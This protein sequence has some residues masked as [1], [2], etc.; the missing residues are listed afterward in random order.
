MRQCGGCTLCCKL[1]PVEEL[2]KPAGIR[3]PHVRTGKGCSIY[4][5][6][7][8]SCR[9]W[10][11]LWL[12]GTE[13]EDRHPLPIGRP[14]RT[15]YV[16]DEVPDLVRARDNTTGEVVAEMTVMQVWVDP[17]FPDAWQDPALLDMLER[18]NVAAL[19]RYDSSRA[20]AIFPPS[21][22]STG[23]WERTRES[24]TSDASDLQEARLRARF[25][26]WQKAA[27]EEAESA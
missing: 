14:D 3:C 13:G 9:H 21:R 24:Q 8:V 26:F 10:S 4:E 2:S 25:E 22:S 5:R 18:Q 27:K 19:I 15:H 23:K 12:I 16:L 6:R 17:K 11:C 1:I 20:F 7:P